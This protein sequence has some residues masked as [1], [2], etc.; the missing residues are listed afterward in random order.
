MTPEKNA[1]IDYLLGS[2]SA[3]IGGFGL[4]LRFKKKEK[5][6]YSIIFY[7]IAAIFALLFAY[8]LIQNFSMLTS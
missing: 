7:T 8:I 1:V 4:G 6:T 2:G 5:N 3:V